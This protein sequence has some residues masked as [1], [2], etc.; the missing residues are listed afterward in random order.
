MAGQLVA[1]WPALKPGVS[2]G[3]QKSESELRLALKCVLLLRAV[4]TVQQEGIRLA[5]R[6]ICW[7]DPGKPQNFLKSG[8][9]AISRCIPPV[10][11]QAPL[12]ALVPP[13][14]TVEVPL[15]PITAVGG[16]DSHILTPSQITCEPA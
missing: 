9:V 10:S 16:L 4:K 1:E 12:A 15:G 5:A 7:A 2:P 11:P 3:K 8:S 13:V 6:E 14:L